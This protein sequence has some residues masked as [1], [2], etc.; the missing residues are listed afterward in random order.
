[1]KISPQ[2]RCRQCGQAMQAHH[3]KT[4]AC[5][6]PRQHQGG[7]LGWRRGYRAYSSWGFFKK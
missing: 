4:K 1:M 7:A 3:K 5:P 2:D 6:I